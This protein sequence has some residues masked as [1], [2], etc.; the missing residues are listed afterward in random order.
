[1]LGKR[2]A[3]NATE[4]NINEDDNPVTS[5]DFI[6]VKELPKPTVKKPEHHFYTKEE[7][8]LPQSIKERYGMSKR[9]KTTTTANLSS[10]TVVN[11][12]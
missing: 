3:R 12:S 10:N 8:A 11:P 1:M 7:A 6:E 5:V 9:Q 2:L 4:T